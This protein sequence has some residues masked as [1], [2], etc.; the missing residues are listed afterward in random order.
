[1]ESSVTYQETRHEQVADRAIHVAGVTVGLIAAIGLV[2]I[3]ARDA[4]MRAVIAIG[5]YIAGLVAMLVCSALYNFKRHS[6]HGDLFRRLDHAVVYLM[7]A[8]TY[9]P[10]AL[11]VIGGARGTGLFAFVWAVA[12]AGAA[13]K[14]LFPRRFERLSIAAYLVLGWTVLT[15][16]GPLREAMPTSDLVLLAAGCLLYS[17]GVAFHLWTRLPFHN[18]IWHGFVLAAATCHYVAIFRTT[19]AL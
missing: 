12:S 4:D 14:F 15:V 16:L 2:V 17:V 3:T 9:S 13:L 11:I 18:A 5:L 6:A 19:T 8:G 10:L 1:V 7:I